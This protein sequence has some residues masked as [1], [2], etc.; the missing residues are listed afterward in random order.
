MS[1]PPSETCSASFTL[2]NGYTFNTTKDDLYVIF[3]NPENLLNDAEKN[4]LMKLALAV[5][6]TKLFE[7][8]TKG[9]Y[10]S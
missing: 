3:D 7:T 10:H 8:E 1:T 2:P 4:G 9:V 6:F 5:L